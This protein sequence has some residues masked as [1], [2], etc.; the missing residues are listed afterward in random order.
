M[1]STESLRRNGRRAARLVVATCILLAL[2][3][4]GESGARQAKVR[5]DHASQHRGSDSGHHG[6]KHHGHHRRKRSCRQPR[7]HSGHH[8]RKHAGRH[9]RKHSGRHG[10]KHSGH[11]RRKRS[12]RQPPAPAPTQPPTG[13]SPMV[14]GLNGA[15]YGTAGVTDVRNAVSYVRL[16]SALGATPVRDYENAGVKID[17]DFSGPYQGGGVSAL[18][19]STWVANALSFYRANTDPTR[20]PFIEVL[21]EPG[22]DWFW[23][24]GAMGQQ[25]AVAY[26]ALVQATYNAFHALYGSSAPKILATVDGGG[27]PMPGTSWGQSWWTADCANFVDG[28]VVHPY[29]GGDGYDRAASGQGNRM[30]VT[31]AYA[32]FGK[33]VY[34]TEVGW[35]TGARSTG[36]SQAWSEAEQA[37]ALTNFMDWARST[38][39]VAAVMYFNYHDFDDNNWYGVVRSDGSHKPSYDALRAEAAR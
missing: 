10:R 25:N 8:R 15:N 22:G 33:P 16:D 17:L 18:D 7:K 3:G 2:M 26:R 34:V 29:G 23:G 9:G 14:V 37:A 4:A 36:D 1:P 13:P 38:G 28:V 32:R 12:C 6:R 11:H 24:D 5:Q 27:N 19:A 39:Y 35:S 20:T 21:N 31:D 30:R